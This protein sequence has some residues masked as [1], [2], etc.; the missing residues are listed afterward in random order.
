[1]I[2]S[3]R[4]RDERKTAKNPA[5]TSSSDPT[6]VLQ[7]CSKHGCAHDA[8]RVSRL[9]P[10]RRGGRGEH[11]GGWHDARRGRTTENRPGNETGSESGR[12]RVFQAS[13]RPNREELERATP[14]GRTARGRRTKRDWPRRR[15]PPDAAGNSGSGQSGPGRVSRITLILKGLCG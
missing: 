4:P 10:G 9:A 11:N 8:H 13:M 6:P 2:T 1:M 3:I 15:K 7:F 14:I 5:E 12:V